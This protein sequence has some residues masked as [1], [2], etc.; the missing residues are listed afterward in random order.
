MRENS[1]DPMTPRQLWLLFGLIGVMAGT[2]SVYFGYAAWPF[3]IGIAAIALAYAPRAASTGGAL[4]GIGV[5]SGGML[6]WASRCPPATTCEPGFAIEPF[7]AFVVVSLGVG[8]GLSGLHFTGPRSPS[9]A[10]ERGDGPA[11]RSNSPRG[12]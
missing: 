7:I 1:A 12:W 2:M 9:S 10:G 6:W 5:G 3:A 4:T 11:S 8:F